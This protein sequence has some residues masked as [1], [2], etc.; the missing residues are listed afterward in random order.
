MRRGRGKIFL[1]NVKGAG[2]EM[3]TGSKRIDKFLK[4]YEKLKKSATYKEMY[5]GGKYVRFQTV[6][7][8]PEVMDLWFGENGALYLVEMLR[9]GNNSYKAAHRLRIEFNALEYTNLIKEANN[10]STEQSTEILKELDKIAN[11]FTELSKTA[12]KTLAPDFAK[13][14]SHGTNIG[15]ACLAGA[16]TTLAA[17]GFTAYSI[18]SSGIARGFKNWLGLYVTT[19]AFGVPLSGMAAAGSIMGWVG[20][21]VSAVALAVLAAKKL[22]DKY[23]SY[24][25]HKG[26]MKILKQMVSS[27]SNIEKLFLGLK[28]C[29]DKYGALNGNLEKNLQVA[30]AVSDKYLRNSK[31]NFEKKLDAKK[32]KNKHKNITRDKL[33]FFEKRKKANEM[34]IEIF[35]TVSNIVLKNQEE[36]VSK[37]E[38]RYEQNLKDLEKNMIPGLRGDK[39]AAKNLKKGK[40]TKNT[41][42]SKSKISDKGKKKQ[43]I[44]LKN[45]K[46]IFRK[47]KGKK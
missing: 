39:S 32:A 35:R 15:A 44:S 25:S 23:Q 20:V 16:G 43:K 45:L 10:L 34:K 7:A 46:T 2:K 22:Y 12:R 33:N 4:D 24:K 47:N 28:I 19:R 21:G 9:F 8:T 14:L 29:V 13:V 11:L 36:F 37:V 1:E 40:K 6:A 3:F 17:V 31:K 5:P 38:A 30:H 41:D 18:A 27:L 26:D 42:A